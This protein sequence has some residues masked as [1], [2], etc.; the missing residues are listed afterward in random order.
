MLATVK[1][2]IGRKPACLRVLHN[3]LKG[4]YTYTSDQRFEAQHKPRS[5]EWALKI[6]SPQKRDSGQYECQISTTPP[7]G[8]AVYLNIVGE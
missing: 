2:S 3:F 6:R 8:H 7:I 5:E 4:R 1:E